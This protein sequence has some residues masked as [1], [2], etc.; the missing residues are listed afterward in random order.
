[1]IKKTEDLSGMVSNILKDGTQ[2][3]LIHAYRLGKLRRARI[4][5]Y[6]LKVKVNFYSYVRFTSLY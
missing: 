6:E 4:A 5:A 1:M 2:S 3:T